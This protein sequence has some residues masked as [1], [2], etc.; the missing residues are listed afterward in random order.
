LNEMLLIVSAVQAVP[1][2][3]VVGEEDGLKSK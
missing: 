2:V 3:P 1:I